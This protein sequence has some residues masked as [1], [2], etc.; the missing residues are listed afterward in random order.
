MKK[1]LFFI[2]LLSLSISSYGRAMF[3]PWYQ[4]IYWIWDTNQKTIFK[5]ISRGDYPVFY[6]IIKD[7]VDVNT[8]GRYNQSLLAAAV[9]ERRYEMVLLLLK[10]GADPNKTGKNGHGSPL[11]FAVD[12]RRLD[13]TKMLLKAGAN[14]NQV[15]KNGTTAL[16]S[17]IQVSNF[18]LTEFLLKSGANPNLKSKWGFPLHYAARSYSPEIIKLLLRYGA[19]V[20]VLNRGR[21][22]LAEAINWDANS[23]CTAITNAKILL[24]A[25]SDVN[26]CG[27]NWSAESFPLILAINSDNTDLAKVLLLH[28][29]NVNKRNSYPFSAPSIINGKFI[30]NKTVYTP[31][32]TAIKRKSLSMVNL[33]LEHGAKPTTKQTENIKKLKIFKKTKSINLF[34]NQGS[35]YLYEYVKQTIADGADINSVNKSGQTLLERTCT[36]RGGSDLIKLLLTSGCKNKNKALRIAIRCGNIDAVKLLLKYGAN[37]N[38]ISPFSKQTAIFYLNNNGLSILPLLLKNGI[39]INHLNINNNNV[40]GA[41]YNEDDMS[42]WQALIKAGANWKQVN[43]SGKNIAETI[44]RSDTDERSINIIK[45]L[46]DL[47]IDRSEV[48]KQAM[49]DK[50]KNLLFMLKH[51]W[52]NNSVKNGVR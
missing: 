49:K 17:A 13:I 14:V 18:T 41:L 1:I 12:D 39:D 25:G 3:D 15:S 52:E 20:N 6:K 2:L 26:L 34:K 27:K 24:S 8:V 29:A 38:A 46:I 30:S 31:L 9:N 22:A 16:V 5:A 50:R 33:L 4:D 45:L 44:I 40:L 42:L 32:S 10:K 7:G 11:I 19:K 37:P 43:K 48:K 35:R 21:T 28:G 23:R 36:N 51:I 47:G